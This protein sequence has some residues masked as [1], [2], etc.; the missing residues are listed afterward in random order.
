M[1][2]SFQNKKIEQK[3]KRNKIKKWYLSLSLQ[4]H[5]FWT[6]RTYLKNKTQIMKNIPNKIVTWANPWKIQ[7]IVSWF[8]IWKYIL[9]AYEAFLLASK[10]LQEDLYP[11]V[12]QFA[13]VQAKFML[14]ASLLRSLA[15]GLNTHHLLGRYSIFCV[16]TRNLF[17]LWPETS[18]AYFGCPSYL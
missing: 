1:F 7:A 15:F 9:N 5:K 12:V 18:I 10:L 11:S 4:S 6:W 16:G 8:Y 3:C 2:L 14:F 17:W 13:K